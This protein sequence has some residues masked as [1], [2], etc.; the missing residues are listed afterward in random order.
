MHFGQM[1]SF[2]EME[3]LQHIPIVWRLFSTGHG[4]PL[5]PP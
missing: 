4:H 5:L 3:L 2:V 1:T